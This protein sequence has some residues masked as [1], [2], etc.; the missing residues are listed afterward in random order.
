MNTENNETIFIKSSDD[1]PEERAVRLQKVRILAQLSRRELCEKSELNPSTYKGWEQAR[2]GGLSQK[3]AEKIIAGL[4]SVGVVCSLDWL[5][6]CTGSPPY[7]LNENLTLKSP[8]D[9]ILTEL[10]DFEKAYDG[11]VFLR[12]KDDNMH[13]MYEIGDWVAGIKATKNNIDSAINKNC[14]VKIKNGLST[15][16]YLR[17]S[18]KENHFYLLSSNL[19]SE[20]PM[21]IETEIDFAAPILRHYKD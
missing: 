16:R 14:I 20:N 2:F 15:V 5:L 21:G 12:I 17:K 4:L 6:N 13:P 9:N 3:G 1:S 18:N 11:G 7:F 8:V 10:M 19:D